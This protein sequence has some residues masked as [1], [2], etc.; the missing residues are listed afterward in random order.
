[1]GRTSAGNDTKLIQTGIR[2][3]RAKGLGGFTVREV[4]AKSRVN[5]GMFH[6]YFTNKDNFN[7]KLLATLYEEL[8]K[9][10]RVDVSDRC[11]ARE[12]VRAVLRAIRRFAR[13][14]RRMLSS[15]VGDVFGGNEKILAFISRNF[16][17]HVSVLFAQLERAHKE[18]LLRVPD[19]LSAMLLLAPPV[20]FPQALAGLS[21]RITFPW[22]PKVK[23]AL[24]ELTSGDGDGRIDLL[25]DAVFK[26]E[27]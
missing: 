3:A 4:C 8:M 25:L 21:E 10:I 18:G 19:P 22:P 27:K 24:R 9:D 12:N 14:N 17:R 26:G 5:L 2:L 23:K 20:V 16:T 1:M 13:E 11:S 7:R 15:M 6:Y